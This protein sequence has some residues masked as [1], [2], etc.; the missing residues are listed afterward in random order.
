MRKMKINWKLR[1]QSPQ[2]WLGLISVI[3]SPI[4]SYMGLTGADLTSWQ[5]I[6]D[7]GTSFVSNPYLI[8]VVIMAVLSFIGIA[9]DPTTKGLCDSEEALYY[10]KRKDTSKP[11]SETKEEKSES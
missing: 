11:K 4:L 7:L 8:G 6:V 2:F 9:T 1:L 5:S 10:N 3:A